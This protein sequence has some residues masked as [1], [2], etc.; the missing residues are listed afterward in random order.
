MLSRETYRL[1]TMH[2]L[3]TDR[4]ATDVNLYH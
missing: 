1:A 3:Q 4:Q 2:L